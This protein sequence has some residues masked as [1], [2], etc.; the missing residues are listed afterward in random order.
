ME[1]K[2]LS[3][4]RPVPLPNEVEMKEMAGNSSSTSA[5]RHRGHSDSSFASVSSSSPGSPPPPPEGGERGSEICTPRDP[6]TETTLAEERERVCHESLLEDISPL[7][8]PLS[9]TSHDITIETDST[10]TNHVAPPPQTEKL[11]VPTNKT[12][13]HHHYT[14][15]SDLLHD[16]IHDQSP[17]QRDSFLNRAPHPSLP[18]ATKG[19]VNG[20]LNMA[21]EKEIWSGVKIDSDGMTSRV[22]EVDWRLLHVLRIYEATIAGLRREVVEMKVALR[23]CVREGERGRRRRRGRSGGRGEEGEEEEE[24]TTAG[25]SALE[26]NQVMNFVIFCQVVLYYSG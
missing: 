9:V 18:R 11:P 23:E 24:T 13:R 10:H 19:A 5:P 1:D 6:Q 12:P 7:P 16:A 21:D 22:R 4:V 3:E 2:T 26:D 25:A 15:T 14:Y 17:Q 20:L 8:P